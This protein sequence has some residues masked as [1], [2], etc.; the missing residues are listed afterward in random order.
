MNASNED[1]NNIE[2][3]IIENRY[4]V[5]KELYARWAK[6]NKVNRYFKI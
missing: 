4:N 5:T 2:E 3:P 1:I 6:E